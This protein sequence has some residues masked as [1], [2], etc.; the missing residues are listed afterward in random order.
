MKR[1]LLEKRLRGEGR[2]SNSIPRRTQPGPAPLSF[3]Q[4]RLWFLDQLMPGSSSYNETSTFRV[5][6]ALDPAVLERSLNEIVRRHEALRTT[7]RIID[8]EPR[9]VIAPSLRLSMPLIDLTEMP[10]EEREAE[11]ARLALE[12]TYAPFDLS[13]DPLVR[14]ALVRCS[15]QEFVFMLT[16]HHIVCD[17]WSMDVFFC[18]LTALYGAFAMG[19]A[20]PLPELP[21][22]YAD[23]AVWQR[24]WLSGEVL[25]EQLS[26]WKRQLANLPVLQLPADR[27]R[28]AVPSFRGARREIEI[29]DPELGRLT[30]LTQRE[31]TTLFITLLAA[32]AELLH[33][34]TGQDDIVIGAPIA[35]RNR[36][37]LEGLIGFF[38]NT[39]VMRIDVSGDPTFREALRRAKQVA[40]AAYAHQDVP[41]EKLVE[42]LRPERDVSRNPLFQVTFQLLSGPPSTGAEPAEELPPAPQVELGTAK[43]DL[44]FDLL[45]TPGGLNG[46]FEYS[47][48]LFEDDTIARLAANFHVLIAAIAAHPDR[49]LSELPLLSVS[50]QAR[51][52]DEWNATARAY[53][54]DRCVHQLVAD[55]ARRDPSAIAV[56]Q[57]D[58]S[59]TY[60]E[61]NRRAGQI[62]RHLLDRGVGGDSLVAVCLE[63]SLELVIAVLGVLKA[64]A[65]YVPLDP[66]YPRERLAFMLADTKTP[67]VLTVRRFLDKLPEGG[68]ERVCLDEAPADGPALAD[69]ECDSALSTS[70]RAYVIYTS[71][72]TGTPRGV[73][74]EHGG[75]L[76]LVAWHHRAYSVTHEDRATLIASPAFDASVWEIWPYLARGASLHI[77]GEATLASP[78]GLVR[79]LT[80]ERITLCFLPTPLAEAVLELSWTGGVRLRGLLTGG[81]RLQHWP[82]SGLPFS[83]FNHYGPTEDTVV[84]TCAPL[85]AGGSAGEPPLGRPISNKRVYVLDAHLQPVPIGVPGELH[86]SGDGLARGYLNRPELTAEKFIPHPFDPRE[87]A[88]LYRTGDLVRWR[89]DGNLEFLGRTDDQVKIRGFRIELG[90]IESNLRQHPAVREAVIV[91]R[92]EA[93]GEK[94]VVAYV[95]PDARGAGAMEGLAS[96]D[97]VAQWRKVFDQTMSEAA[98]P[99]D[100][101]FHIAGWNSSYTGLPIPEAEMREQV[102]HASQRILQLRPRRVL[103]IGCGTGLLLFR[104]A[105]H[106]DEYVGTDFSRVSLDHV[107]RQLAPRG[108]T[109]VTLLERTADDFELIS[110]RA[111]DVVVLN[112][113]VQYFSD[114]EYLLRVLEGAVETTRDGGYVFVGD[115]RGLPLLKAFR[116]AVELHRAPDGMLARELRQRIERRLHSEEELL[117]DPALFLALGQRISRVGG[118]EVQLKR[119]RFHN[120]LTRYRYDCVLTAGPAAGAPEPP[121]LDWAEVRSLTTVRD[122]V[123]ECGLDALAITRVPN[124]R[125]ETDVRAAD[126][127]WSDDCPLTVGEIKRSLNKLKRDGVD[128]HDFWALEKELDCHVSISWSG[129]GAGPEYDVLF[130]RHTEALSPA[131]AVP[132]RSAAPN[133]SAWTNNPLQAQLVEKLTPALKDYLRSR[134]PEYMVPAAVVLLNSLPLTPNGKVDRR[135]LPLPDQARSRADGASGAPRNELERKIAGVWREVLG[136]PAVGVDDNFFDLGGHSMMLYR[137]H[138]RLRDVIAAEFSIIDLFRYPTVGSLAK[139]LTA[140][141]EGVPA[142][143]FTERAAKQREA[144]VRVRKQLQAR[145]AHHG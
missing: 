110:R 101:A 42:E 63:R 84:T 54:R 25:D 22:Q 34:Y 21:I 12:Q 79:W 65:A 23:F 122:L 117:V 14:V 116:T 49:R 129:H 24:E 35:N 5:E 28:P 105:P 134:L 55:Q 145:S 69:S 126:L 73:E 144:I 52:L 70:S 143:D 139:F 88:R 56:V 136:M 81:D 92:E 8:G 87:G 108:L 44:R 68:F 78:P 131:A 100:G 140:Q 128:P 124:A 30:A 72:S 39:L 66:A 127:L 15:E 6:A 43:F 4:Q 121:S 97:Q 102:E 93:Y 9:Q 51:L 40:L 99:H 61:L 53:S 137:L 85:L 141:E 120:E 7:F 3:A 77:P 91:A 104:I 82:R 41:F 74:I 132:A 48:D 58:R 130:R 62:A 135:A 60:S 103:E 20:S 33:R 31:G 13:R 86:I 38:V 119:G 89:A 138:V 98:P 10:R 109:N 29:R 142:A 80:A 19:Q 125:V 133:W 57:Q 45:E 17:G 2:Q 111:F 32:F 71:G 114:A 94:R 50:E 67:V 18:E 106:C 112:S 1:A 123:R 90:E 59:L 26:Y 118:I 75:L 16:M 46:Q 76:N 115:I 27:Q 11:I 113:V 64:G 47:T 36:E 83:V 37:E 96:S 107:R 95:V